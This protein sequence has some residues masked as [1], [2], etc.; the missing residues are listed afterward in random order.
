MNG[1][2]LLEMGRAIQNRNA[3]SWPIT[4]IDPKRAKIV[5]SLLVVYANELPH[6]ENPYASK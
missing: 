2:L 6:H 5:T 3:Y 1:D 4:A